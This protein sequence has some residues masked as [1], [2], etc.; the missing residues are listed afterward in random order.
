MEQSL[1]YVGSACEDRILSGG[2]KISAVRATLHEGQDLSAPSAL[3]PV[4]SV[5]IFCLSSY[6]GRHC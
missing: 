4:A 1:K 6:E 2:P 3:L 5:I